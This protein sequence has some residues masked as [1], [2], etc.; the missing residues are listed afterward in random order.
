M[1]KYL[2]NLKKEFSFFHIFSLFITIFLPIFSFGIFGPTEIFFANH[3]AFGVIFDEFGMTFLKNGLILTFILTL[4]LFFFPLILKKIILSCIWIFSVAGYVQTMFLNKNLDQIGA[5]TDGYIPTSDTLIKDGLI[6]AAIM[7]LGIVLLI[8]SK[9]SWRKLICLVSF[10]L[11][12]TQAVAYSTLFISADPEAFT[13][14]ESELVISGEEQYTVSTQE[15]VIVFVLDTI[16]NYLYER[17]LED[18]P[19]TGNTLTDFTYFNNTDCNYFGTFPSLTHIVTGHDFDPTQLTNDWIYDAWNNDATTQFYGNIHN[20]GYLAN[21]YSIEPVLFTGSHPLSLIENSIDNLTVLS[22]RRE[23]NYPLLYKTL[24]TMSCYRFMPDYFKP[25]FDVP[26]TQY[27]SIVTYPDNTIDYMNPD[28]YA[29]LKSKGLSVDNENKRLIFY[30]LNGIHE[31]I[32]DENCEYVTDSGSYTTTIKGIWVMLE[33]YLNQLKE[34]GCYDNS[35]IIITSDHGSEYFGQ[36]IFFIKKAHETH[37]TM[38]ITNA[39]ISLDE[40]LPTISQIIVGD[41]TYLGESIYDFSENEQRE[42]TLYIRS[43]D[44]N[45]PAVN[46][47]DG[48]PNMGSNVYHLYT[49]TGDYNDYVYQYENYIYETVP[50]ADAYY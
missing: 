6:W 42:R 10:I 20:A 32:N 15:N 21:V 44:D 47:Y 3:K 16:S 28:F 19:E 8:I 33:E 24:L 30:H 34:N 31:L 39:P 35:T 18:Y 46:R 49:Y 12:A 23:I 14:T 38:Q 9:Q 29:S 7:I 37:D 48:T 11:V 1:S 41:Y 2:S 4:V 50:A 36:S 27:A 5:T 45:Y 26:N 17:T 40:L 22:Q 13:Y 43:S 25:N